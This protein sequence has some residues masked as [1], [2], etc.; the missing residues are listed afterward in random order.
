MEE[1][2]LATSLTARITASTTTE[3][4]NLTTVS[5]YTPSSISSNGQHELKETNALTHID[6]LYP[7][8]TQLIL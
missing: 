2:P 6:C 3:K 4:E 7:G 1:T 5:S 8:L